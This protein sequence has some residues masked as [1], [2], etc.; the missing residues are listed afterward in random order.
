MLDT[1][2]PARVLLA[3][4]AAVVLTT[5]SADAAHPAL[6]VHAN[7]S[8]IVVGTYVIFGKS[9]TASFVSPT[10]R[11]AIQSFGTPD[12]CRLGAPGAHGLSNFSTAMWSS[13]GMRMV[14]A[15]YGGSAHGGDACSEP[16]SF[17]LDNVRI[18]GTGWQT[19]LG[20][21]IGDPVSKLKRLYPGALPHNGAWWI[22]IKEN[23]VGSDSLYPVFEATTEGGSVTAFVL[24]IGAEGD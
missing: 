14:F 2:R 10:Y 11:G 3:A 4:I 24:A 15:S 21:R 13:L 17:F 20:L 7:A 1:R 23:H 6:V 18:T 16:A 22:V 12:S 9:A 19:G 5:A 8:R